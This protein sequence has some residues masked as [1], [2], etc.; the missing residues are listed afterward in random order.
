[1]HDRNGNELK[2]GDK[3]M[4][5]M[6]ITDCTGGEDYCNVSLESVYGR[7]PDSEK[8][9]VCAVNTGICVLL[10]K[11]DCNESSDNPD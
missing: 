4:V 8:E 2:V 11:A 10:E 1:M 6:I 5:P 3:V 9:Q 7:R